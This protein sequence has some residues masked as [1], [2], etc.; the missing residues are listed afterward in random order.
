MVGLQQ[1][2]LGSVLVPAKMYAAVEMMFHFL[3]TSGV[4]FNAYV[5]VIGGFGFTI[6]YDLI[7]EC[8]IR[9]YFELLKIMKFIRMSLKEFVTLKDEYSPYFK[10]NLIPVLICDFQKRKMTFK[11]QENFLQFMMQTL[12]DTNKGV[13]VSDAMYL[14]IWKVYDERKWNK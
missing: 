7:A 14:A 1:Y 4:S 10:T 12:R 6:L 8:K 11:E 9:S 13:V 2:V 3:S 5:Q